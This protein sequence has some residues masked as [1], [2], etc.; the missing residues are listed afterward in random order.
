MCLRVLSSHYWL[1]SHLYLIFNKTLN[2]LGTK[3]VT[4][5]LTELLINERTRTC[6]SEM[7]YNFLKML[8]IIS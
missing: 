7:C 2:H 5:I 4:E 3:N 6:E 1:I 8:N